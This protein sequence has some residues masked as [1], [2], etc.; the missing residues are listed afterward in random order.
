MSED[1][2]MGL[3]LSDKY[4]TNPKAEIT[5]V[6]QELGSGAAIKIARLGNKEAAKAYKKIPKHIRNMVDEGTLEG[7]DAEAFLAGYLASNI[8]KDWRG[9]V[10]KGEALPVYST[11][12][13]KKFMMKYRRFR[14]RVWELAADDDLFNVEAEED[15]KNL[16]KDF[17]GGSGTVQ[18]PSKP[19]VTVN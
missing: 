10:D 3:D 13:G 2:S 1:E 8:L 5:G 16:P 12:A 11:D 19:F 6:W 9:L 17:D 15:A 4:G 14:E 18:T 7:T